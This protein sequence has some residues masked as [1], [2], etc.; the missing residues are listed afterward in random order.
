MEDIIDIIVTETTNLITITS[1]GSDEVIDVNIIDNREDI[2]LNVTPSVVEININSLTGNFGVNWGQITGTLSNQTDLNTALGLKAD[3]VGGK[4]P[5][6][7]LPSY[8]DDVVEVANYAALPATGETGKIYITL[9]TNFMY[10]WSGSTYIEIKDSSAVWG[11]I[12]GTLSSQTDLQNALNAK[13]D[14]PTGD[15]TQY[16]AGDG[17]LITFPIAGQSGTLVREVRN[18][19][20]ATLTKGTIVYISG[21]TGNKPTVSKAIATADSTSAQTFGMC[22]A[23]I[24][25]NSNGYVVCV[26]DLTGLDTSAFTEGN[27][28]YLSSTT[29][30]TYTVTKQLAPA[31][32][33]YIGIVTR[34]HPTQGQIEVNIQNGYELY[35]L[36]DVSITS[37]ADNQGLFYELSTDLWKNKSIATVLG[38]TPEPTITAGTTAQYYRGDKTFQTL[39]TTAVAEGTNLYYTDARA[40]TAISITVT[41][42]SGASTYNST[43]GVLN[44]PTYT[45]AGLGGQPALS[46][47]GF[48][49]ISGTTISYDNST[50]LTTSAAAST[51]LALAGGTMTG[52]VSGTRLSLSQNSA[53]ITLSISNAGTGRAFSVLGTSYFSTDIQLGY[54]TNAILKTTSLGLITSAIAGTDYQAPLSGTGFVKISG[55]TISYDNSTYLTTA[56]ASSTYLT[57]ATASSTYL[58]LAGGTLTGALNGTSALFS[59]A[60]R[61]N[62]PSEGATGEG[63]IAGQSF[64]IDGTGTS[65]RAVMYMVSNVLSDTYASGLT[66]Q[67]GNFAGDKGFGF[68]LNTSG[69]YELYVKNT[70]WNKALT[71]SNT[72]AVTLTGAL[73][74]TSA[75]FS[76]SLAVGTTLSAWDGLLRPIEVGNAGNFYAGFNGG[77]AL[78]SGSGMYYSGGWKYAVAS[79]GVNLVD[80]GNGAFTFKSAASGTIGTAVTL[81]DRFTIAST[82]AATFSSSVTA[83]SF[84]NAGLQAGEVF[85]GTKSNSGYFVGYLQNTSATGLGLYIQNGSDTLDALRIGNA[86]GSANPI[87][88]YGSGKALFAGNVGIGTTA[89]SHKLSVSN[90]ANGVVASF[91]NTADADL[92]IN[93]TSGVTLLT[94]STGILAFGTSS[95]ER[96][97]IT[98]GGD[99]LVGATSSTYSAAGR[100]LIVAN[101]STSALYGFS[102]G[103]ASKGYLYHNGTNLYL[104]N[105]NSGGL[106]D[107]TQVG[108]GT[109]T[110][111]TNGSERMRITSGGQ[112]LVN[113]TNDSYGDG[114]AFVTQGSKGAT[115]QT[116]AGGGYCALVLR[117]T[118]S[119]GGLTEHYYG[120]TYVGGINISSTSSSYLT[121]SDYRLKEDLKTIN[122]LEIVN[123][124]KVYDYKWKSNDSRMDGVLAHELA[125]VLPYAVTGVKDGVEMQ[126]VDYSKIVP[127]MVQAIKELKAKIETLE[128]K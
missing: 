34:A 15:T 105:A 100:G 6:S 68:N 8:V 64:K 108:A 47:T 7:Q 94:P 23:N 18:T 53:D 41:G 115:I 52:P 22:Q 109:I 107:I 76:G 61:A 66:A 21:A 35:E 28:L 125:E 120:S 43:T 88:L 81:I 126:G 1:S 79:S 116:T 87:Q 20:G 113:I 102:I 16:I 57:I 26:G 14:D 36:H 44:V 69:G 19:T 46:G 63:L 33:V 72:N 9:D 103:G 10:R 4:V 84:S 95:T 17:S 70:T 67:F 31:H 127:V 3:L 60:V 83:T 24:S 58:P 37:E 86:A 2:V 48:V 39:N 98:S 45:L 25:N 82:G 32:L 55:S 59:G 118:A 90:P 12:T 30:G 85:N 96:M 13:F 111:G 71:I 101:G 124:I 92:S 75:T 27:Q 42:S 11:A 122:G 99:L 65:Q 97:R 56:S 110:F 123:K 29:A 54:A 74:G 51:Y 119:D 117:R 104:E 38:Y 114:S 91:T 73:S 128:N 49:K 112:V 121:S 77:S 78:Y 106:F 40:R 5:S 62:N 89:P 50:Y 93:L 80:I